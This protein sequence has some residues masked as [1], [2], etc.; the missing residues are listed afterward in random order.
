MRFFR[1]ALQNFFRNFWLSITSIIIILLMLFSLSLVYGFNIL[2][3]QILSSFKDK[4]DLGVYLNQ[5]I[6]LNQLS[7]LRSELENMDE[8]K[9]VYYLTPEESLKNFK[10]KHVND[11]LILKSLE[12]LNE[13][14]LGGALTLKFH[15]PSNYE[16]VVLVINRPVYSALIRDKNFYD[17]QELI[18]GFNQFN[19]KIIGVGLGISGIF[20][21]ITILVIFTTIKLGALSRRREI[22]IMRLVGA[23]AWAIRTPFLIEGSLYAFVAW[24]IN[25]ALIIPLTYFSQPYLQKFIGLDFNLF[26]YLKTNVFYFWFSLLLFALIISLAGSSLAIKKY[27]KF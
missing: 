6:D 8:I 20:A 10:E 14:P 24:I 21:L 4:M 1:L 18:L 3:Q 15:D 2:G 5:N 23:S 11:P 16:K 13:N 22:K 27:L 9:E 19:Q 7:L 25:S 17:Y 12:E 26:I